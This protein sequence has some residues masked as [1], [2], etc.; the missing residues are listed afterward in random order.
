MDQ[1]R[2]IGRSK[3]TVVLFEGFRGIGGIVIGEWDIE[4]REV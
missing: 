2:E 4:D 3:S 1:S